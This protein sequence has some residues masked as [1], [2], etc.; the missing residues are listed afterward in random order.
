MF[1]IGGSQPG[2]V[3]SDVDVYDLKAGTHQYFLNVLPSG[4]RTFPSFGTC[5]DIDAT[6]AV[7][8]GN[9]NGSNIVRISSSCGIWIVCF[10]V[11]LWVCISVK[12]TANIQTVA[13]DYVGTSNLS[14]LRARSAGTCVTFTSTGNGGLVS[15]YA[16][17]N[18]PTT[19]Y[20]DISMFVHSN[21]TKS[22]LSRGLTVGVHY[23][24]SAV[25]SDG[26]YVVFIGGR[27]GAGATKNIDV[28]HTSNVSFYR[29]IQ[30]NTA[31]TYHASAA[32]G[33]FI[34]VAG[35]GIT[36]VQVIDTRSWIVF[37]SPETLSQGSTYNTAVSV[38]GY[39]V[40]FAG[41]GH[42]LIDYFTCGNGVRF[43]SSTT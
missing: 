1:F 12:V 18:S 43:E 28:F 13:S 9:S 37:N 24:S 38:P 20:T 41:G 33:P 26:R 15:L 8:F 32:L 7:V 34:Y 21:Y 6:R 31:M 23:L 30:L 25:T 35:G 29:N 10:V 40:F 4:G 36:L 17:G 27:N 16:G 39:A 19:F 5:G 3:N 2:L 11:L 22:E 42:A 14:I